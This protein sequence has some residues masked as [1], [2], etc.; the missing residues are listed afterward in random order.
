MAAWIAGAISP[1]QA[2]FPRRPND[3]SERLLR[4][5]LS[6]MTAITVYC[7]S[8]SFLDP[9]FHDEARAVGAGIARRGWTLV[10]GGGSLG[11]MGETARAAKTAGSRVI[12]IITRRLMALEQ[13]WNGCDELVVVDTMRERKRM[14]EHRGDAFL[15]LPGGL[16]TYEE[17]FEILVGKLLGEHVKPVAIINAHGYFNPLI[18]MVEHG[19]AHRF[20]PERA[21]E[22]FAISPDV[23]PLLD[24]LAARLGSRTAALKQAAAVTVTPLSHDTSL[25]GVTD[26]GR[27]C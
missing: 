23:E 6:G 19:I 8:S 27:T 13:G 21:R 9:A 5:A 16:G 22:L 4:Y 12:G 20:I 1:S 17:L 2:C 26:N 10:Y 24:A 15:V 11:L 25:A 14:L 7:S 18:A 3:L